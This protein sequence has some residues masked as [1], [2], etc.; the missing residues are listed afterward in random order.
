VTAEAQRIVESW[1]SELTSV[2]QFLTAEDWMTTVSILDTG[3]TPVGYLWW[4]QNFSVPGAQIAIGAPA[5]AWSELGARVLQAAGVELI[6]QASA[7]S[8][9]L[10]AVQ[11]SMSGMARVLS[12]RLSRVVETTSGRDE[13]P[14]DGGVTCE[15]IVNTGGFDL[16]A[17][18]VSVSNQMCA[19]FQ[20]PV[21]E[22][23]LSRASEQTAITPSAAPVATAAPGGNVSVLLDVQMP[24]SICFGRASMPLREIMK[25][26]TGSAV[27][28]DRRPDDEVDII[29]NN[30]VIARGEVVV[31]DGNYGVRVTGIISREQRL[32]LR[33]AAR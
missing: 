17:L 13:A 29:V 19:A 11:Q 25:L 31:I 28:L 22:K 18:R 9:Y 3:S 5:L 2:L 8:T 7:K 6:E 32:A 4:A 12:E 27:E 10:E 30:C 20:A 16:P 26:A 1:A 15:V 23:A 33:A 14:V 21:A 24:V